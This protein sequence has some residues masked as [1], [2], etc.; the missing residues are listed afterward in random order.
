MFDGQ[1]LSHLLLVSKG[2]G[3]K[4]LAYSVHLALDER[5]YFLESPSL[6]F[7]P[8]KTRPSMFAECWRVASQ[9]RRRGA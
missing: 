2:R 5:I 6:S 3:Q 8:G 7:V 4:V 1:P 9:R